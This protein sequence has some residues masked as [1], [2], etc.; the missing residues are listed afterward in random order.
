MEENKRSSDRHTVRFKIIY[1]DGHSFNAG[2]VHDLSTEGLF[3]ETCVPLVPGDRVMLSS[4]ELDE[5]RAFELSARVTRVVEHDRNRADH[6]AGM[7]LAFD[8]L[9][10][11]QRDKLTLFIQQLQEEA[12]QFEGEAD[13][14]F[15]KK[16]PRS[17]LKRSPSGIWRPEKT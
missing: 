10:I 5:D 6:I 12:A 15:G 8:K 3:L 7:G 11:E 16:I 2:I 9:S 17:G 13:P 14:Y 1:D 4:L